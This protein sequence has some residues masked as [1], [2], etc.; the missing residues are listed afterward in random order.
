MSWGSPLTKDK[1]RSE[2]T[3]P[4]FWSHYLIKQLHTRSLVLHQGDGDGCCQQMGDVQCGITMSAVFP[5]SYLFNWWYPLVGIQISWSRN[6]DHPKSPW[7]LQPSLPLASFLPSA[8]LERG[9]SFSLF[10]QHCSPVPLRTTLVRITLVRITLV[11]SCF[12][13]VSPNPFQSLHAHVSTIKSRMIFIKKKAKKKR[14]R[15]RRR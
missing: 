5:L 8:L 2:P 13:I 10:F 6:I 15:K 11:H 7:E 1:P 14:K 4:L 9:L 3:K 12:S